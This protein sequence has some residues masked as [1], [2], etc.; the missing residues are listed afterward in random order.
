[1][2]MVSKRGI[3]KSTSRR[4]NPVKRSKAGKIVSSGR[5]AFEKDVR[6]IL[7]S[8]RKELEEKIFKQ[9]DNLP[10]EKRVRRLKLIKKDYKKF[11]DV[12]KVLEVNKEGT[13]SEEKREVVQANKIFNRIADEEASKFLNFI[14]GRI[15]FEKPALKAS[16]RVTPVK[17]SLDEEDL[18][19]F[20]SGKLAKGRDK[21]LEE[22]ARAL[23]EQKKPKKKVSALKKEEIEKD[24]IVKKINPLLETVVDNKLIRRA[25]IDTFNLREDISKKDLRNFLISEEF[26]KKRLNRYPSL[27]EVKN[28]GTARLLRDIQAFLKKEI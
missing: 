11:F 12:N 28:K 23:S 21:F 4:F 7:S 16:R 10:I 15:K 13:T 6:D 24:K 1:M 5:G 2:N 25:V 22:R 19:L 18:K 17:S 14:E 27:K 9:V 3:S 20:L 8:E 26:E